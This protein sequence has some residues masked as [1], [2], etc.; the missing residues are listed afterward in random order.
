MFTVLRTTLGQPISRDEFMSRIK[1]LRRAGVSAS[2]WAFL[3]EIMQ[4]EGWLKVSEAPSRSG[5]P[6][7]Y[8]YEGTHAGITLMDTGDGYEKALAIIEREIP[9]FTERQTRRPEKCLRR[10]LERQRCAKPT[11]IEQKTALA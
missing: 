7:R 4:E 1:K 9:N 10:K 5:G 2:N 6:P 11:E 3:T 8:H